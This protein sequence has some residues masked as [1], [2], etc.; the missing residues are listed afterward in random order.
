M[1]GER[2]GCGGLTRST[3]RCHVHG[4]DSWDRRVA[5]KQFLF[6]LLYRRRAVLLF[7]M[8]GHKSTR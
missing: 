3:V 2:L 5:L 6:F 4:A 1:V 7:I 8:N